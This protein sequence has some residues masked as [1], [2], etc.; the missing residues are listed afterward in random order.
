MYARNSLTRSFLLDD[1]RAANL[2]VT[3]F[4]PFKNLPLMLPFLRHFCIPKFQV[5]HSY[6]I[7]SIYPLYKLVCAKLTGSD[8]HH[9]QF[10]YIYIYILLFVPSITHP[11]P[12]LLTIVT[13]Y[14]RHIICSRYVNFKYI[15][16]KLTLV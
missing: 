1:I 10:Y 11:K 7:H 3:F 14:S 8:T 16:Y 13:K 9:I 12:C 5:I 6:F 15:S 4:G 2:L